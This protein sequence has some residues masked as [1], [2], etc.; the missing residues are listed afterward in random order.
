MSLSYLRDD[1]HKQ[2]IT[3]IRESRWFESMYTMQSKTRPTRHTLSTLNPHMVHDHTYLTRS[4]Y[5]NL[6]YSHQQIWIDSLH[7]R[8]R[9]PDTIH[10]TTVIRSVGVY[11]ASLPQK[12]KSSGKKSSS[13]WQSTIRLTGPIS[14]ACDRYVQYLLVGTNRTVLNRHKRELQSWRC[15]FSTYHSP[16]FP[17]SCLPFSLVA[18]PGLHLT[19]FQQLNQSFEF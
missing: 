17:T 18:P 12:P 6:S 19:Q 8:R 15:Q 14:P 13:C 3:H 4:T 11:P 7:L 10:N 2:A 5:S 1:C 16:T 9:A